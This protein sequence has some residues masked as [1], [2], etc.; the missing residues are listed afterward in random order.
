[1]KPP[2]E[3]SSTPP[4]GFPQSEFARRTE[5]LQRAM[6]RERLDAV[7]LTTEPNVRYFSGFF[8][9]FWESPTRPWFL[10]MPARGKPVAVIPEI[11]FGG[12]AKTWGRGHSNLAVA[13]ARR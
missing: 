2:P 12:M 1:M 6:Q 7:L 10:V 8:T 13:T 4:R 9:Q 3:M 11:G 5:T